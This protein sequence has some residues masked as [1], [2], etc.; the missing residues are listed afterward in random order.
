M[1]NFSRL[2]T[3]RWSWT[4]IFS[5]KC[6]ILFGSSWLRLNETTCD[7]YT[8]DYGRFAGY[9]F[10]CLASVASRLNI[11]VSLAFEKVSFIKP[12]SLARRFGCVHLIHEI[13]SQPP[14]KRLVHAKMLKSISNRKKIFEYSMKP[15]EEEE[16]RLKKLT[17][18]RRIKHKFVR[19]ITLIRFLYRTPIRETET[20]SQLW[21]QLT[22]RNG[23]IRDFGS[24]GGSCSCLH[25]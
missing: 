23:A 2:A 12:H 7:T 15:E 13:G 11:F 17:I 21:L 25:C 1:S 6:L 10:V 8:V 14:Q 16:K 3:T 24:R 5:T 9:F 22:Q 4:Q 18:W 20:S 19:P